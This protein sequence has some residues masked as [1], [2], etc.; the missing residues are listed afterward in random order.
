MSTAEE[1]FWKYIDKRGPDECWPWKGYRNRAGYGVLFVRMEDGVAV[2]I[3]AHR[4]AYELHNPDKLGD[5]NGCHRCDNPPCCNHVHVFKGSH[6]DNKKDCVSKRRHTY[7]EA[8]PL[9]KLTVD[10]VKEIRAL[11]EE[12]WPLRKIGSDPRFMVDHKTILAI[13]NRRTW[14]YVE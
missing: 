2:T 8:S 13:V 7:G 11:R 12:G 6:A 14:V 1:R 10:Q 4:F 5:L 3:L 9:S